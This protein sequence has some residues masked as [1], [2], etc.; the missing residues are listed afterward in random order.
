M[1]CRAG[2]LGQRP[3]ARL[4][5]TPFNSGV[6]QQGDKQAFLLSNLQLQNKCGKDLACSSFLLVGRRFCGV[7]PIELH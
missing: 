1:M 2:L 5:T 4:G 6:A 7:A 3:E